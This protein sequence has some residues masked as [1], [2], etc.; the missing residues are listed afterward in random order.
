M[1]SSKYAIRIFT[2]EVWGLGQ[3][4]DEAPIMSTS[5]KHIRTR[6]S[7]ALRVIHTAPAGCQ[8]VVPFKGGEVKYGLY[9]GC[10]S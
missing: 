7:G 10:R 8:M 4:G 5:T 2:C 6:K 3:I 9:V 1:T